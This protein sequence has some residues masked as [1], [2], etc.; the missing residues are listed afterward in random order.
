MLEIVIINIFTH[1]YLDVYMILKRQTR[2]SSV[3]Y[4]SEQKGKKIVWENGFIHTLTIKFFPNLS[5]K[6]ICFYLK[7]WIPLMHRRFSRFTSLNPEYV[8]TL[9]NDL[10]NPFHYATNK[11]MLEKNS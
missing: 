1:S 5:N 9:C 3:E 11:R 10:I 2:I 6:N 4:F 7:F 8:K